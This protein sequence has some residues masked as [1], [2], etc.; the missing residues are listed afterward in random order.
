[1]PFCIPSITVKVNYT[2]LPDF[3]GQ[4]IFFE[5]EVLMQLF[6]TNYIPK[7]IEKA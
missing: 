6:E 1:M 3:G 4:L 5:K 7:Y 2:K